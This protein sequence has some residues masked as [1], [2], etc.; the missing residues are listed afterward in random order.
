MSKTGVVRDD[1]LAAEEW[2]G[3][4]GARW[5][6]QL[7]RFESMIA[8]VGEAL[9]AQAA[10]VRGERV[11]DIGSGGGA[12]TL[13][14][15]RTVGS[16]GTVVGLDISADLT[17]AAI[18][19]AQAAGLGHV[20]FQQ[21]DAAVV[22]PEEA[23]FDRLFSRFGCMFFAQPYAAFA[24][25][26]AMIRD[27][28]GLD[29]AVWAPARDN[30]WIAGLMEV[31]GRHVELPA[32]VPRAP[33][34]FALDDPDYVRDLLGR[35]GFGRTLIDPW[36]VKLH[37]G[38]VGETPETAADFV[39]GSMHIGD[40]VREAAGDAAAAVKVGLVELFRRHCEPDGIVMEAKAWLVTARC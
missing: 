32:P 3:E 31:V 21:G 30:P 4:A 38:G 24:N 40:L 1:H 12:T 8:P 37:I 2:A 11:V 9:L 27:G 33:G 19:R 36:V 5:L 13:E 18:A 20:R 17:N 16:D 6:A 14:I 34:P 15:A 35:A 23:P 10:F 7:D 26:R 29:I 25:L 28:G 22:M 39:L